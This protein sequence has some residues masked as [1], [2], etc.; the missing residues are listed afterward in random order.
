MNNYAYQAVNAAGLQIEGTLEVSSQSEALRR[1]KEMGLFPTKLAE[2]RRKQSSATGARVG[3]RARFGS[4]ALSLPLF[5]GRVKPAAVVA[6]TRQLATLIE[7]G[8]PLLRGLRVLQQQERNRTL[9]RVIGEVGERIEAGSTLSEALAVHPH[10]FNALYIN[11]VKA[12]EI[13]GALEITLKRLAEFLEKAQK[14]KGKIKAAMFYPAAVM[15][16]AAAILGGGAAIEGLRGGRLHLPGRTQGDSRRHPGEAVQSHGRGREVRARA[17]DPGRQLHRHCGDQPAGVQEDLR[18][19][20]AG[21]DRAGPQP[22]RH[23][24]VT[25][26]LAARFVG[27]VPPV[28]AAPARLSQ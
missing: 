23:A 13:G 8:M 6:F 17:E 11:M 15:F 10:L 9:N 12:G 18:S 25:A 20:W 1:I 19:G 27:R 28:P 7:A 26:G 24:S 5:R 3:T 21:V 2:R 22:G 14:I 4:L 16:V